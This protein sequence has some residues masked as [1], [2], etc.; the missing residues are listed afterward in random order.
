MSA[1][2]SKSRALFRH[3]VRITNYSSRFDRALKIS[4][5][6]RLGTAPRAGRDSAPDTRGP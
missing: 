1:D 5:V 2:D 3:A 4:N 6:K